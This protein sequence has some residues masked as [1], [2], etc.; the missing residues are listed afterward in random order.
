VKVES[1]ISV[2]S[3]WALCFP[4]TIL[5]FAIVTKA[6]EQETDRSTTLAIHATDRDGSPLQLPL[7]PPDT[8]KQILMGNARFE[9]YDAKSSAR[10]FAGETKFEFR[11]TYRTQ[12]RWRLIEQEG[13]PA[14]QI[15]ITYHNVKLFRSH[16]ILLPE[17]LLGDDWFNRTLTQHEF[18]HLA[19]SSDSRLPALLVSMLTKRNSTITEPLDSYSSEAPP[20]REELSRISSQVVAESSDKV[21]NDFVGLVSIRYREL[22]RITS[23]GRSPL[24]SAGREQL[25]ISPL[26][27][28][29]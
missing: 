8:L 18:D 13:K 23:H 11:Y 27:M 6:N 16:R 2:V 15:S 9:F 29:D 14:L 1:P 24:S 12:S 3:P 5:F 17:E 21:F 20:S 10:E 22:D 26:A 4:T 28:T 19:I 25:I 7:P